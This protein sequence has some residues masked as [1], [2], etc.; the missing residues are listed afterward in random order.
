MNITRYGFSGHQGT[1]VAGFP[2]EFF[3]CNPKNAAYGQELLEHNL[4][5]IDTHLSPYVDGLHHFADSLEEFAFTQTFRS[6]GNN[7]SIHWVHCFPFDDKEEPQ[8]DRLPIESGKA[9]VVGRVQSWY[10][11]KRGRLSEEMNKADVTNLYDGM[12][13][14]LRAL[15]QSDVAQTV[16]PKQRIGLMEE[17]TLQYCFPYGLIAPDHWSPIT[18]EA[19]RGLVALVYNPTRDRRDKAAQSLLELEQFSEQNAAELIAFAKNWLLALRLAGLS[20]SYNSLGSKLPINEE[21]RNSLGTMHVLLD[22]MRQD[23]RAKVPPSLDA[24]ITSFI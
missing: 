2:I 6:K 21:L 15:F 10:Q 7:N 3:D 13:K 24:L 4:R 16:D 8:K 14:V 23:L 20:G 22:S 18:Y 9:F 19:E 1:R 12:K 5:Q 17:V 11:G